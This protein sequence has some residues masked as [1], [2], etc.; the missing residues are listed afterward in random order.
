MKFNQLQMRRQRMQRNQF[1]YSAVNVS[2][3]ELNL[4][5]KYRKP[6]INKEELS[7]HLA[8]A[9]DGGPEKR[10]LASFDASNEEIS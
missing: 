5:G 4:C 9:F 10:M 6:T 1:N 8:A 3:N 7:A 2:C